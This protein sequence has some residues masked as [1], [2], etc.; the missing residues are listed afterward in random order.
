MRRAASSVAAFLFLVSAISGAALAADL[1]GNCC[2]DLEERVAALEATVARKGN[3]A[4]S[5][6]ISGQ[7]DRAL[8]Y[9]QD[10]G[11]SD[12]YSV[13]NFNQETRLRL[14]GE[15]RINPKLKAGY[16]IEVGIF[17]TLTSQVTQPNDNGNETGLILRH[18][19]WFLEHTELGRVTVGHTGSAAFLVDVIDLGEIGVVTG[20]WTYRHNGGL[21]LRNGATGALL[22]AN[23]AQALHGPLDPA[24][25]DLVKY[26][27]P[28]LHGFQLTAAIGED[29]AWDV[30][31]RYAGEW[32]G[33]RVAAGIAYVEDRDENGGFLTPVANTAAL[34]GSRDIRQWLGS[35]SLLHAP[36]GVFVS[37]AFYH[38]ELNGAFDL[39]VDGAKRPDEDIFWVAAGLRKN[40]FGIGPTSIY[41]EYSRSENLLTGTCGNAV[42]VAPA[43]VGCTS[44]LKIAA[45]ESNLW[46]IGF[47]QTIQSAATE[48]YLGYR[49][50]EVDISTAPTPGGPLTKQPISDLDAVLA[51]VRVKF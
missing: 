20:A 51:G 6:T 46:G 13:G 32:N 23:W 22:P 8:L 21:L 27:S 5:L 15:G 29:D 37:A 33:I 2:T 10:S 43:G 47:V 9:W 19:Y 18:D 16:F 4:V 3:K 1:A 38:R 48:I 25:G 30:A 11:E 39:G 36:S 44:G 50:Q 35:A 31:L 12:V 14:L 28:V 49:H 40:W 41:A 17:D 42:V 24:R 45:H 34:N 7:V 26:D